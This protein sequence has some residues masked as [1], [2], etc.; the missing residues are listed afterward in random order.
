MKDD[1]VK[2]A[3]WRKLFRM[4]PSLNEVVKTLDPALPA[5]LRHIKADDL[6][7]K[8]LTIEEKQVLVVSCL[9]VRVCRA[10]SC[11]VGWLLT[12]SIRAGADDPRLQVWHSLRQGG[13]DER[14][15]NVCQR[16]VACMCACACVCVCV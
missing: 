6:P 5:N 2:P 16:Y 15:R 3:W 11:R 8:I 12:S 4:G 14:G 13:A 1:D 7:A 10:V 9:V